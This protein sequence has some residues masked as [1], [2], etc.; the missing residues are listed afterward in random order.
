MLP[1]EQIPAIKIQLI[2]QIEETF[3]EDKKDSSIRQIE[4]MNDEALEQFLI[5]NHLIKT[6]PSQS[7]SSHAKSQ[8]KCIFCSIVDGTVNSNKIDENKYSIAILEINPISK[9]HILIIPKKHVSD[10]DKIP[11]QA[12]S[13]AKKI[14]KKLKSKLKP[15]SVII[16]SSNFMGHEI[17]NV[18][19]VY[20]NET[21]ESEKH[22][23]SS[24]E[25][26]ELK[27]LLEKKPKKT[28][29]PKKLKEEKQK[30]WLPKRIP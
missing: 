22:H 9:G 13:L 18:L 11:Q 1:K 7:G 21:L 20:K 26:E 29:K 19:P 17:I 3:P 4:E 16:N 27:R 6:S 8:E 14:S 28:S 10:A 2:K 15:K 5:Q 25:L 12:F 23:A 24:K 30:L